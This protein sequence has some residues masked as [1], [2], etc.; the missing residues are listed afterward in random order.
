MFFHSSQRLHILA[1]GYF[2]NF[3][4]S[5][6][7]HVFL[8][9]NVPIT[10]FSLLFFKDPNELLPQGMC[11]CCLFNQ[12]FSFQIIQKF[13]PHS[14]QVFVQISAPQKYIPCHP[15]KLLGLIYLYLHI[16]FNLSLKFESLSRFIHPYHY[17]YLHILIKYKLHKNSN[18]V[19][20]EYCTPATK[21]H[22]NI[23][24]LINT[25]LQI[26]KLMS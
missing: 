5:C 13:L 7:Y 22:P 24:Q 8:C 16:L 17:F 9:F 25:Y 20:L 11:T 18:F 19:F 15:N 2:Y 21:N 4:Y 12:K 26:N 1:S 14:I 3:V 10:S 23:F 6:S